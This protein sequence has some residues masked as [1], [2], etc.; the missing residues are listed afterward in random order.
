MN[1]EL[2]KSHFI[3]LRK[4]AFEKQEEARSKEERWYWRGMAMAF[5]KAIKMIEM[6]DNGEI[7]TVE[8]RNR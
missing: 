2:M 3:R 6:I 4:D 1:L 7:A 8:I 5:K